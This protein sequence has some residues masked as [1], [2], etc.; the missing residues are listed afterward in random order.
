[1]RILTTMDTLWLN[2][3]LLDR[4]GRTSQISCEVVASVVPAQFL[5]DVLMSFYDNAAKYIWPLEAPDA[6][7][8]DDGYDMVE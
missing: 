1:M 3:E 7:T 4:S 5:F 8:D 6:D 2:D